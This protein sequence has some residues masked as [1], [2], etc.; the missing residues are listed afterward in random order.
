MLLGEVS[1]G[2]RGGLGDVSYGLGFGQ[3]AGKSGPGQCQ[4]SLCRRQQMDVGLVMIDIVC[5]IS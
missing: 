3:R 5:Q 1:T 2:S 4:L